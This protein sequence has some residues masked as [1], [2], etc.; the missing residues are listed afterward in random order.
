M[1][2]PVRAVRKRKAVRRIVLG[3]GW[4]SAGMIDSLAVEVLAGDAIKHSVTL[5]ERGE[6]ADERHCRLVLE[7]LPSRSR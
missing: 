4:R 3:T 1:A 2:K 6:W 7:V 5:Y